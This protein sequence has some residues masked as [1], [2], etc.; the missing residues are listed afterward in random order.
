MLNSLKNKKKTVSS[1]FITDFTAENVSTSECYLWRHRRTATLCF[2]ARCHN[3]I[4]EI[5]AIS[6]SI[7]GETCDKFVYH[8]IHCKLS[9][10][11]NALLSFSSKWQRSTWWRNEDF[12]TRRSLTMV[13]D[14]PNHTPKDK[15]PSFP[16]SSMALPV[17][18]VSEKLQSACMLSC[19]YCSQTFK[20]R[21][22]LDKHLKIHLNSGSLKCNICDKI[23]ASP[24][25]LA[26]HKLTHCKIQHGNMCVLCKIPLKSEE[27][28]Y[29][30]S[31]EHGAQSSYMQCIVCRQTL[32]SMAELQMHRKHHFQTK[33]GFFSCCVCLKTFDSKEN[34]ISKDET[35]N[36]KYFVCKPCYHGEK[37]EFSCN[38]CNAKF[39]TLLQLE[40]HSETHRKSYQCIKCQE[41]FSSE[42]EIKLHVASHVMKEGNVHE[43]KLCNQVFESPAKLQ[44][45]L[46]EHTYQNSDFRC[47]VC[48]KKFESSQDI[49]QHAVEHGPS[50]RRYACGQC[51]QKFF[52]SAELENHKFS[53]DSMRLS[54]KNKTEISKVGKGGTSSANSLL[55]QALSNFNPDTFTAL[56]IPTIPTILSEKIENKTVEA[57]NCIN[58]EFKCTEC[59]KSFSMLVNLTNHKKLHEKRSQ[60]YKC[61]LCPRILDSMS[62]L[63]QHFFS[64][65]SN[66]EL[67][68]T[69]KVYRCPECKEEFPCQS[70]L[71]GHMRIHN[72]GIEWD[73]I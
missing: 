29:M 40:T 32:V 73:R 20:N 42:H 59:D 41:S 6:H 1:R 65:H 66:S 15:P 51:S 45:H 55:K 50:S 60:N 57:A 70:N 39:L 68:E 14:K 43:C 44:C 47:S 4:Y 33:A 72:S 23:F 31:Q 56:T 18:V 30:H 11:Y 35:G 16:S 2:P 61:S 24:A 8:F 10:N 28:F 62:D 19:M 38:Q 7:N 22:D 46:I 58:G 34:L 26:E 53:H 25:V 36:E 9:S 69:K 27:E 71:Q 3:L 49:Q 48:C 54:E 52:F 13:T 37:E 63:Q 67:D 5:I 21:A 12:N 17:V 64:D